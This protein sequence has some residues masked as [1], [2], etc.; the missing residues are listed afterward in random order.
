M[1]RNTRTSHTPSLMDEWR[2]KVDLNAWSSSIFR[3]LPAK[4]VSSAFVLAERVS[5]NR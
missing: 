4:M 2:R 3:E 1:S 5:G